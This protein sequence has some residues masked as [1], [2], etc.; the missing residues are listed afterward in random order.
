MIR[1]THFRTNCI[2]CNYCVEVAPYRWEMDNSDGKSNLLSA[3]VKKG[4]Y[5]SIVGNDEYEDN[6]EAA[7][8]CPVNIIKVEKI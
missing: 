1:I 5:I 4:I 2:G 8:L 6:L 7:D 3:K